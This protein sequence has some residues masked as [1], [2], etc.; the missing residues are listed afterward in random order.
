MRAARL[1]QML[2]LLQNRGRL[3]SA[4][5]AE[6]L[7]VSTRTILRDVDAMTEAGLPI[8]VYQGNQGGIELGFEYRTRL[9]GLDADEAAAFAIM[10]DQRPSALGALGMAD[11]GARAAAKLREAFPDQ[12]RRIMQ[13]TS[14]AYPMAPSPVDIDPRLPALAEAVRKRLIVRLNVRTDAPLTVHPVKLGYDGEDWNLTCKLTD[15]EVPRGDWGDINISSK[16]F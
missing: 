3:T 9:T 7:E 12:T 11:A 16:R 1:L 13:S 6:E 8:I 14:D 2:L 5:L 4:R 10:L 15:S